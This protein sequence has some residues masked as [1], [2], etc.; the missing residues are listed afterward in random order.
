M[1]MNKIFGIKPLRPFSAIKVRGDAG[2]YQLLGINW[3]SESVLVMRAGTQGEEIPFSRVGFKLH[4]SCKEVILYQCL[5]CKQMH[6]QQVESCSCNDLPFHY[7]RWVAKPL[8]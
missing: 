1:L 4:E 7:R 3:Q 2:V 6:Q 5:H 8:V